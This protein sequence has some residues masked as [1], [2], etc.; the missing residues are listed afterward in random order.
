MHYKVNVFM[1]WLW[2]F[3]NNKVSN[4]ADDARIWLHLQLNGFKCP[5]CFKTA[6]NLTKF[7]KW[8]WKNKFYK[9]VILFLQSLP[10]RRNGRYFNLFTNPGFKESRGQHLMR[11]N[12][13]VCAR[14]AHGAHFDV[15]ALSCIVH[16]PFL[17]H[18]YLF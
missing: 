4:D 8:P 10:S 13:T 16:A 1:I 6:L 12:V 7:I 3:I 18:H 5:E 11:Y 17:L 2:K 15:S 9:V 14:R